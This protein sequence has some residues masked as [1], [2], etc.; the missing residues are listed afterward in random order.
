MELNE[1]K[2]IENA[3]FKVKELESDPPMFIVIASIMSSMG[4]VYV[5]LTL[6]SVF[7]LKFAYQKLDSEI[8]WILTPSITACYAGWRAVGAVRVVCQIARLPLWIM[9]KQLSKP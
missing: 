4:L 2:K 8:D 9:R 6:G 7:V 1:L 5:F 3:S